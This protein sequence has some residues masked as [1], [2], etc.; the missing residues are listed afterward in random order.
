MKN[1]RAYPL[2]LIL[3]IVLVAGIPG[4]FVRA[5]SQN[6]REQQ[7]AG[8]ADTSLQIEAVVVTARKRPH[9]IDRAAP[10]VGRRLS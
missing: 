3:T 2:A 4:H 5:E 10:E 1:R 7:L 8:A 9:R 6:N